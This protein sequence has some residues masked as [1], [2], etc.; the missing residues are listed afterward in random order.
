VGKAA[1][2]LVRARQA[3]AA[4]YPKRGCLVSGVCCYKQESRPTIGVAAE[5]GPRVVSALGRLEEP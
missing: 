1:R 3:V 5:G 2:R 4:C